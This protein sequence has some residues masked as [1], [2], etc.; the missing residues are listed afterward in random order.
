MVSGELVVFAEDESHLLWGDV[1]GYVWHTI[2]HKSG[3]LGESRTCGAYARGFRR[4]LQVAGNLKSMTYGIHAKH[5]AK[6]CVMACVRPALFSS[7]WVGFAVFA[8]PPFGS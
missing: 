3:D 8:V 4:C 5:S 7:Y 2:T 1:Q 6:M